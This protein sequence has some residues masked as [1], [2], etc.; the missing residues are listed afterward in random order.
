MS[1]E[2]RGENMVQKAEENMVEKEGEKRNV[3]E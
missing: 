2:T 3:Q 1:R